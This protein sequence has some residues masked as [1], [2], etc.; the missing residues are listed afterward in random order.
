MKNLKRVLCF[1]LVCVLI[2]S[3]LPMTAAAEDIKITAMEF[4]VENVK[5]GEKGTAVKAHVAGDSPIILE[6][7]ATLRYDD[8]GEPGLLVKSDLLQEGKI[9]WLCINP[10]VKSG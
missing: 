7:L 5:V 10:V 1:V 3:L 4:T 6:N 2:G 9:Y 8:A